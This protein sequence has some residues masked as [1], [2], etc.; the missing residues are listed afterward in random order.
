MLVVCCKE[1]WEVCPSVL[2]YLSPA[3]NAPLVSHLT[4]DKYQT[5]LKALQD[6]QCRG[7]HSPQLPLSVSLPSNC[8]CLP[9]MHQKHAHLKVC[10]FNSLYTLHLLYQ[11]YSSPLDTLFDLFV[12]V[13]VYPLSLAF[14]HHESRGFS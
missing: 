6:H 3:Q 12:C 4:R 1:L 8:T 13:H 11:V 2:S 7:T 10:S 14:K 9:R 5:P